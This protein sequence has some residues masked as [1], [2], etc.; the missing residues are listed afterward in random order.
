MGF[1]TIRFKLDTFLKPW[2]PNRKK[3]LHWS[4]AHHWGKLHGSCPEKRKAYPDK[5]EH[6]CLQ[7]YRLQ[8][9]LH[10]WEYQQLKKLRISKD[11]ANHRWSLRLQHYTCKQGLSTFKKV[12]NTNKEPLVLYSGFESYRRCRQGFSGAIWLWKLTFNFHFLLWVRFFL[13]F[14]LYYFSFF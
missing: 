12:I 11:S 2:D 9:W 4:S 6:L 14:L 7:L 13:F 8:D 10:Y 3:N 1:Q 5:L